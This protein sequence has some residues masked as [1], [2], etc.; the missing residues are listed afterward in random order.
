[1][2]IG[3][4]DRGKGDESFRELRSVQVFSSVSYR[5]NDCYCHMRVGMSWLGVS[6]MEDRFNHPKEEMRICRLFKQTSVKLFHCV[7]N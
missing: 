7:I 6:E 2:P 5:R 4:G 3:E 1:M